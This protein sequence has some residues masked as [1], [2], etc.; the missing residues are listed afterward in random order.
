MFKFVKNRRRSSITCS[1]IEKFRMNR[2]LR[3]TSK[4]VSQSSRKNASLRYDGRVAVVTGAGNGLGKQY[5]L[6]LGRRGA[7]VIVNDLGG[8]TS[9]DGASNTAADQVVQEIKALGGQ[10]VANYANVMDTEAVLNPVLD[11]FGKI[12][13]LI[14]NA[15]MFEPVSF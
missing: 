11:Q 9:G 5:A 13:I 6:E 4:L 3:G 10:A 1:I 15:G 14:N 8:S 12:D 2:F 7:T